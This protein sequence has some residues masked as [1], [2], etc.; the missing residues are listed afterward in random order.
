MRLG[1]VLS[2]PAFSKV[3][4]RGLCT[5]YY[6][7]V[8]AGVS[9]QQLRAP[10]AVLC[11]GTPPVEALGCSCYAGA[12]GRV[13][14][15]A[16]NITCSVVCHAQLDHTGQSLALW[17]DCVCVCVRGRD[18]AGLQEPLQEWVSHSL[19]SHSR[20]SHFWVTPSRVTHGTLTGSCVS[21]CGRAFSLLPLVGASL[22]MRS[23]LRVFCPALGGGS[24]MG[25]LQHATPVLSRRPAAGKRCPAW[26]SAAAAEAAAA[27]GV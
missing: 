4:P 22:W 9:R 21:T 2:F 10:G 14:S 15:T 25:W 18:R 23:W 3:C 26:G 27:A 17:L 6:A 24:R 20:V 13:G 12:V 16:D 1:Q 7:G 5:P 11:S 8:G 19:A